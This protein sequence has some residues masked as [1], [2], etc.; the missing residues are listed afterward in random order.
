VLTDTALRLTRNQ[1]RILALYAIGE[2][3][4]RIS[5]TTGIPPAEITATI[6]TV[7]KGNTGLARNLASE[8]QRLNPQ[9]P[10]RPLQHPPAPPP[11][12][13]VGTLLAEAVAS[14]DPRLTAA[15]ARIGALVDAL[16]RRLIARR[17]SVAERSV[18]AERLD[19]LRLRTR[20]P[21][22]RLPAQ[23]SESQAARAWA[24]RNGYDIGDRGR[25]PGP[26]LDAYRRAAPP[27]PVRTTPPHRSE[28]SRPWPARTPNFSRGCGETRTSSPCPPRSNAST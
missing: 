27:V 9:S 7:A 14:G 4:Q 17:R 20:R 28:G 19:A 6:G 25:I 22:G 26:V 5:V 23:P 2:G 18:A 24:L 3:V 10:V 8:W 21:G 12:D 13:Q 11:T 16:D 15:A 1:A